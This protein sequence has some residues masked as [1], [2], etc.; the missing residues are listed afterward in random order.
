MR[1]DEANEVLQ[2]T[3]DDMN[4]QDDT[5][6]SLFSLIVALAPKRITTSLPFSGWLEPTATTNNTNQTHASASFLCIRRVHISL[7]RVG[8]VLERE[9]RRCRYVSIQAD[10]VA[11]IRSQVTHQRYLF[12]STTAQQPRG[13][14]QTPPPPP[15][16]SPVSMIS[17][18]APTTRH[19]R[20]RSGSTLVDTTPDTLRQ[21][22]QQQQKALEQEILETIMVGASTSATM[23]GHVVPHHGNLAQELIQIYNL[24]GRSAHS[25]PISASQRLS[26]QDGIV[27]LNQH[28]AVAIEAALPQGNEHDDARPVIRPYHTLLFPDSS[29]SELLEAM[30]DPHPSMAPRPVQQI[31]HMVSPRKSLTQVAVDTNLPLTKILEVAESMVRQGVCRASPV[32]HRGIRL[33]CPHVQSLSE[34]GLA[35]QEFGR[36][37]LGLLVSVLTAPDRTL[38]DTMDLLRTSSSRSVQRLR[39]SLQDLVNAELSVL[40]DAVVSTDEQNQND[41]EG[42]LYQ[43]VVW[44][45][46]HRVLVHLGEYL[47]CTARESERVR[48]LRESGCLDGRT[49]ILACCAKMGMDRGQLES[50]IAQTPELRIVRRVPRETDD[51]WYG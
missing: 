38:G 17:G 26:G 10:L 47:V 25:F 7:A 23:H 27:H 44:L 48:E 30:G 37:H 51:D 49:S 29:P 19:R 50:I 33:A 5:K 1:D 34:L 11:R 35:F 12:W 36:V 40:P 6:L 42:I 14:T 39:Q 4:D 18:S 41:P 2:T 8:R 24:L 13:E 43:M 45:C 22:Q 3:A 31:L 21:Q 32:V 15:V 46:S 20:G 28:L 16:S 9:E